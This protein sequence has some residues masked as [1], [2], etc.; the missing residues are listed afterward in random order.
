MN[1]ETSGGKSTPERGT[2]WGKK[3]PHVDL[4]TRVRALPGGLHGASQV[5]YGC[6]NEETGT[7]IRPSAEASPAP[8]NDQHLCLQLLLT[9]EMRQCGLSQHRTCPRRQGS[10]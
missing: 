10:C 3:K 6:I 9:K 8:L 5:P 1:L 2:P 7:V 4:R